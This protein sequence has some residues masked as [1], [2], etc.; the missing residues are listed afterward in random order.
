[1]NRQSFFGIVAWVA[2]LVLKQWFDMFILL[3]FRGVVPSP[4]GN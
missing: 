3:I 1:M 2:G 4:K